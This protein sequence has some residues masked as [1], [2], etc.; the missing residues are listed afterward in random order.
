MTPT[1]VWH[2]SLRLAPGD[3]ALADA[4]WA[5]AAQHVVAK[6]GLD[7]CRWVT[8]RHA[9]D[10][11]H[12]AAVMVGR[13]GRR[14]H[15]RHDYR[16]SAEAC[17]HI[18]QR[19]GLAQVESPDRTERPERSRTGDRIA[20]RLGLDQPV[21]AELRD[22]VTAA[23]STGRQDFAGQLRAAGVQVRWRRDSQQRITGYAVALHGHR[24]ARGEPVWHSA[25]RLSKHLSY[26]ALDRRWRNAT[27]ASGDPSR[28]VERVSPQ[29]AAGRIGVGEAASTLADV[30]SVSARMV[31]GPAGQALCLAVRA[32]D[33]A[34]AQPAGGSPTPPPAAQAVVR[35]LSITG[36]TRQLLSRL[37]ASWR[38]LAEVPE[39]DGRVAAATAARAAGQAAHR[40]AGA[41]VSSR[42]RSS[43][44]I[45]ES[46][47]DRGRYSF[48][49]VDHRDSRYPLL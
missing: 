2:C 21:A 45:L 14:E 27:A 1:S 11:V 26:G 8:V 44:H 20:S 23:A 49:C 31:P 41:P 7:S 43:Q 18:E 42:G 13:D 33:R 48:M 34:R 24:N 3:R 22:R 4:E 32:G 9:D 29:L 10:H 6:N 16:R 47:Q 36:P 28:T 40:A 15:A 35:T 46:Q 38:Q 17:R 19:F 37:A 25:D 30:T 5:E 12:V 39:Q